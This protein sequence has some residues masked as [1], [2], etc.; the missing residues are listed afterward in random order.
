MQ[1]TDLYFFLRQ[2]FFF[3]L[4]NIKIHRMYEVKISQNVVSNNWWSLKSVVLKSG[5]SLMKAVFHWWLNEPTFLR[6]SLSTCTT[7]LDWVSR[8]ITLLVSCTQI[9]HTHTVNITVSL[10]HCPCR[11][12]ILSTR[13]NPDSSQ[14]TQNGSI[15]ALYLFKLLFLISVYKIYS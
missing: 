6:S 14:Q 11:S 9:S 12:V 10:S 1:S 8:T 7:A 4:R 5:W 15:S 2:S 13:L 3:F